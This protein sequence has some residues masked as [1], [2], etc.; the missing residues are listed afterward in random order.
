MFNTTHNCQFW[1][2]HFQKSSCELDI[3]SSIK[4]NY[5]WK[6]IGTISFIWF[7]NRLHINTQS[8]LLQSY[9]WPWKSTIPKMET[10]MIFPESIIFK[11][12][13]HK[14]VSPSPKKNNPNILAYFWIMDK[15]FLILWSWITSSSS[16]DTTFWGG[17]L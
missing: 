4:Q 17:G 8:F 9:K 14:I 1:I 10:G 12:G 13:R 7:K 16:L 11:N 2:M 3:W 6:K 15:L 5:T